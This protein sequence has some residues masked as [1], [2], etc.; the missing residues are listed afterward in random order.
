MVEMVSVQS[1][2]RRSITRCRLDINAMVNA[3]KL[4]FTIQVPG[5]RIVNTSLASSFDIADLTTAPSVHYILYYMRW[6]LA[7]LSFCGP[8]P[9]EMRL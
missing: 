5:V 2:I 4:V 7:R 3:Y 8:E 1:L 6:R 9:A